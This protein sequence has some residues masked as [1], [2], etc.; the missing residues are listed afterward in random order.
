MPDTTREW[1]CREDIDGSG[2]LQEVL[3]W[4]SEHGW[5]IFTVNSVNNYSIDS[6]GN[7]LNTTYHTVVAYK[8]LPTEKEKTNDV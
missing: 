3:T 2:D 7:H 8:D 1:D 5:T 4:F 6:Y